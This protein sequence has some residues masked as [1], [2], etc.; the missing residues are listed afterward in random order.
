M[1]TETNEANKARATDIAGQKM[2]FVSG[3]DGHFCV[4]AVLAASEEP[5][6]FAMICGELPFEVDDCKYYGDWE[7]KLET[8]LSE[9]F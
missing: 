9:A 8:I 4:S 1:A 5:A 2:L 3:Y 6:S 7:Y